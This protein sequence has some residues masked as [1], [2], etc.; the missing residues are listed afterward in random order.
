MPT[1]ISSAPKPQ[2]WHISPAVIVTLFAALMSA[3]VLGV[4]IWKS[5][6]AKATTLERGETATENLAHSLAEH[7]SHT[8]QAADISMSGIVEFLKYQTPPPERFNKYLADLVQGLP[9]IREI[10]VFN[11]EGDWQYSSLPEMPHYNN[12]D[13]DYFIYH[14]DTQG[15]ALKIS[16]PLQS[17]LTGHLT[18]ILSKRISRQDGSFAGVLTAAIDSDYFNGFY[19]RMQLGKGGAISLIRRDGIVLIRW[20][21]SN[22][23]ADLSKADLFAHQLKLSSVGYYRTV[24]P[25]DGETKYFGYEETSQYP[26]V[27][28]VA[29]SENELLANWWKG[30]RTDALVGIVLLCMIVL[31]A[32]LLSSLFRFRLRTEQALRERETR[33]RL[34]ADN[35]A[36]I[37]ILLDGRGGLLYVSPSVEPV[38]GLRGNDL[39]GKSCFDLVHY[40]DRERV[41]AATAELANPNGTNTVAFRIARA[42]GSIAWV[43]INFKLASERNVTEKIKFVGVVRDVTQRKMMEDELNSLNSRLAQLATTDGLTGLPNRRTLDAFLHREYAGHVTI[44]VLLFDIDHFK[45]YNDTFGHQAGDECLKAVAATIADATFST[46]GMSAR[47]GGEEFAIILPDVP[48]AEALRVA[49]A[50]RLTVRS[51]GI[52]NPSSPRGYVTISVGVATRTRATLNEA[53]LVGDADLALYE[54]KRQGRNSSFAASALK[55][56]FVESGP[57]QYQPESEAASLH[58]LKV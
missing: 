32:A 49:E 33:Y 3:C 10:G 52:S 23:G 28:T 14:R 9:Q 15:P 41:Q 8:I 31:L 2:S 35:I 38:L 20:P 11:A 18:I 27:V 13:R 5:L 26:L 58:R 50:V 7:A 1:P 42:D 54:A 30:L 51:L 43:E 39:I 56:P 22:V 17:R 34:L 47:Y 55:A 21:N 24:S 6:D 53:T 16:A 45:S 19:N 46:T 12:A 44:S 48:E 40:E 25:F 57:L 36:D 37:V 29:R 4:V